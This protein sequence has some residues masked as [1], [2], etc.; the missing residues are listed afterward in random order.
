MKPLL[1]IVSGPPCSGK[2][3]IAKR[4]SSDVG[5]PLFYK[6]G[7]KERLFD[8]LGW[9]DRDWSKKIGFASLDVLFYIAEV[10]L[11]SGKSVM[12]ESNFKSE[13]S[14]K[15]FDDLGRNTISTYIKFSSN[16]T[17]KYC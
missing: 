12:L 10:M 6:D 1:I 15:R 16:V 5:I 3:T 2:T 4:L 11:S 17:V 9:K 7:F 8:S 14:T 13:S